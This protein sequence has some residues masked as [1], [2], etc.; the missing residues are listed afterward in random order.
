MNQKW[1]T[2][3]RLV[4][5][6]GKNAHTL[7]GNIIGN[8]CKELPGGHNV[9]LFATTFDNGKQFKP[10]KALIVTKLS[11]LEFEQ[12]RQPNLSR[13]ELEKNIR[14]RGSDYDVMLNFHTIHKEFERKI[15][16]CFNKFG[17]EVKLVNRLI[18]TKEH[19]KWADILVPVGGDGTFLMTAGRASV[20]N[21]TVTKT[22][23]VGFNS[24]PLR[25]EGR[26][27]LPKKYSYDPEEAIRRIVKGDFK[28]VH[29]SRIRVTL[30]GQ[31][32]TV[33][34]ATDLHENSFQC[35]VEPTGAESLSELDSKKYKTSKMFM[36]PYLALNEVFIG[37][38]LSARV[39]YLQMAVDGNETFTKTKS[40]GLCVS[41]GTG[42]TSWLTSTN[43]LSVKNVKT[44]LEIIE[45]KNGS[46]HN[47]NP[48]SVCKEYN[49]RLVFPPDDPRLCYSIREQICVG[50]WP[51]PK[52]FE[53][54]GFAKT[55]LIKS[56]CLDAS[57]V[58]DGSISYPFNDGAKVLL[59]VQPDDSLLT[60]SID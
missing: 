19:I 53:S 45:S 33:P 31:N 1:I 38:T 32:G 60:I 49:D 36:V 21:P 48:S 10:S 7:I 27:M 11:R 34:Q 50:V 13:N 14:H 6:H 8:H 47:V 39:S 42:S 15:A 24:D 55:I 2:V 41:T 16:Q 4:S 40:S 3:I 29:R 17:V 57:L 52:G 59:E 25:S 12:Q 46:L 35:P 18:I 37:E 51:N 20:F 23:L 44:L 5:V 9:R 58:L 30:F 43:R 28:W 26:L 22:P 54:I 56:R